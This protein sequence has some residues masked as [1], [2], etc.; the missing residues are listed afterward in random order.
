MV[1]VRTIG[2]GE[3]M[4]RFEIFKPGTHTAMSGAEI[5]FTEADLIASAAAYDPQL[6]EAP[7]V[8][9]HPSDNAPAWGWTKALAFADSCLMADADQI[10][11]AFAEAV[12]DG[13]YKKRSASF[14]PPGHTANPVPGVYYLRHI[15]FLGAQPPAV[16]GLKDVNFAEEDG[17]LVFAEME[18]QQTKQEAKTMAVKDRASFCGDCG[19]NVCIP[20]C[21]VDAIT[22]T[23]EKGAVI[24]A[25]KCT[26]CYKCI[27]ACRMM[28]DPVYGMQ[29]ANY[30]EQVKGQLAQIA[31]LTGERN[32]AVKT[33]TEIQSDQ[34]RAGFDAFCESEAM[35]C[36]IS[37]AMKPTVVALMMKLDGAEPVEFGEG[38]GKVMKSP[39][40]I[41]QEELKA[42][43]DVVQFSEVATK[44]KAA[45]KTK[46]QS[47]DFGEHADEDRLSL[48]NK[49]LE[50]QEA[51]PGKTYEQALVIVQK[52]D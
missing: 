7:L 10:D 51:N 35:R 39:L 34:R 41:Y 36:K 22:M 32:T 19:E 31:T 25:A 15:G 49:V 43:P 11:V 5:S 24:D 4:T 48:H 21:P 16:K 30:G 13:K 6:H 9:G 33:L 26:V 40:D 1:R 8:I 20:C 14:Y 45:P 12:N 17:L 44:E 37:P 50:Y 52:Q 23:P 27:D 46:Q 38:D 3:R 18:V 47:A 42:S 2:N 29:V 28:C